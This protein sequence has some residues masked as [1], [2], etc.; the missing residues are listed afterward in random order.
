VY[1]GQDGL[2]MASTEEYD[3]IILDRMLPGVDGLNI[4][5]TLRKQKIHTPILML[6][7]KNQVN[8]R[9]DGLDAGADDYLVK[10]FAFEE[11]LARMRALKRRPRNGIDDELKAGDLVLHA[12]TYAVNRGGT[13]VRLSQKEFALLEYL[14]RNK[15]KTIAKDQIIAHVW[16]YDADI[17]PNTLEAFIKQLRNKVDRAFPRSSPLIHTVRGFGYKISDEL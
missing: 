7:A 10:P 14:L 15:D 12:K 16:N 3:L 2:D 11:L 1:D 4:S 6:T 17:L 13:P 5:K 8:D 9:V